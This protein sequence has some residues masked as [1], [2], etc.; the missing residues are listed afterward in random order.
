L[1]SILYIITQ[2]FKLRIKLGLTGD[3]IY[4]DIFYLYPLLRV[5]LNIENTKPFIIVYLFTI[6]VYKKPLKLREKENKKTR[7]NYFE[8]V[9]PKDI[10]ISTYYGFKDPFNA[11]IVCGV[12]NIIK[13]YIN[14]D[15]MKQFPNFIASNDYIFV[16]AKADINIGNSIIYFIKNKNKN[17]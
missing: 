8:V 10:E 17:Y 13:E 9:N 7:I 4:C 16:D 15:K 6:K 2:T 5:I 11:G 3:D 1:L 12:F 14:I